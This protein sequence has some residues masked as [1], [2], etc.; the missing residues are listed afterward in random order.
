MVQCTNSECLFGTELS[1]KSEAIPDHPISS[2][3]PGQ[4]ACQS[5]YGLLTQVPKWARSWFVSLVVF[6]LIRH[7]LHVYSHLECYQHLDLNIK[8]LCDYYM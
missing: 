5:S 3:L 4:P 2:P 8:T 6:P 7:A 1:V